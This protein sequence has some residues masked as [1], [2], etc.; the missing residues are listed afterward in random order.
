[1][2]FDAKADLLKALNDAKKVGLPTS[3]SDLNLLA[4]SKETIAL[5]KLIDKASLT[6]RK[7]EPSF[8][9]VV[10]IDFENLKRKKN[11]RPEKPYPEPTS[12][13]ITSR[14]KET[15]SI[16]EQIGATT[17]PRQ[18]KLGSTPVDS[19]P[20]SAS[21]K[22]F[23][24]MELD[25]ATTSAKQGDTKEVIRKLKIVRRLIQI[26]RADDTVVGLLG[27]Q[28]SE[29]K[30]YA[31]LQ[32][33]AKDYP[34][35]AKSFAADLLSPLK[36]PTIE[37][38][39]KQEFFRTLSTFALSSEAARK[40]PFVELGSWKLEGGKDSLDFL[41]AS[42]KSWA[43]AFPE[44]KSCQSGKELEDRYKGLKSKLGTYK[45]KDEEEI[46]LGPSWAE[47]ARALDKAEAKRLETIKVLG[48]G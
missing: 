36:K 45:F 26:V 47:G 43:L 35:I 17:A 42:T 9:Q 24:T 46:E 3:P 6:M 37:Q 22:A 16:I 20:R 44:L 14:T 10:D 32:K 18:Y 33:M 5:E 30:Y 27:E 15:L 1:M 39:L 19:F 40:Q 8:G 7:Y 4:P 38:I 28:A 2:A 12:A 21:V 31:V 41:I 11:G 23:V 48:F 34:L 13:Q 25:E 29:Q